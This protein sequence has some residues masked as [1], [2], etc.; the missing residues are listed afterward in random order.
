MMHNHNSFRFQPVASDYRPEQSPDV[1]A[2]YNVDANKYHLLLGFGN[3]FA[4]FVGDQKTTIMS[5]QF[6]NV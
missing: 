3:V 5:E 6:K 2:L 4:T 1:A